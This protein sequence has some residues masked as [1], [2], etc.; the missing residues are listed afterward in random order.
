MS[1]QMNDCLIKAA[2]LPLTALDVTGAPTSAPVP[3]GEYRLGRPEKD[4][5]P[6]YPGERPDSSFVVLNGTVYPLR[7]ALSGSRW[8]VLSGD[9]WTDADKWL[10][11]RGQVPLRDRLTVLAYGSNL[12]PREVNDVGGSRAIVVL[13]G[14]LFGAAAAYCETR[15]GRDQQH[16]AGLIAHESTTG[17]WHGVLLVESETKHELD[18][19]EGAAGG[20]YDLVHLP[21]GAGVEFVLEDGRRWSGPL[22]TYRHGAKRPIAVRDGA[23]LLVREHTQQQVQG[24][25]V[26]GRTHDLDVPAVPA[27][28]LAPLT[29]A[30]IPVFAYGTLQPGECRWAPIEHLVARTAPGQ[31]AGRRIDTG[32]GFP[33][34]VDLGS[35]VT[36][37]TVLMPHDDAY[38]EFLELLDSIEGHPRLYTRTLVRLLSGELAWAY[39]WN[40]V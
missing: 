6:H 34:L 33:G 12:N 23:P 37:G 32:F 5:A 30:P 1:Q 22:P 18:L 9:G 13:R 15:R 36:D 39:T 17:E 26:L 2:T 11:I 4:S 8:E 27:P 10:A 19:K 16:P 29:T 14:A 7:P 35:G 25:D 3:V 24:F 38:D 20:W 28:A 40:G 21:I 31:V